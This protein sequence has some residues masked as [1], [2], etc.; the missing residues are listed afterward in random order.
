[1]ETSSKTHPVRDTAEQIKQSAVDVAKTAADRIQKSSTTEK[2]A[3]GA[4]AL[5]VVAGAAVAAYQ[6]SKAPKKARAKSKPTAAK[7]SPDRSA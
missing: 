3:A 5:G 2:L 7:A 1:M 4:V 6:V